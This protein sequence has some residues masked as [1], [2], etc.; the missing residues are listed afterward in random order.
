MLP[1]AYWDCV[2]TSDYLDFDAQ[3][4]ARASPINAPPPASRPMAYDTGPRWVATPFLYRTFTGDTLPAC[5]RFPQ[6]PAS[7]SVHACGLR[8]R[9]VPLVLHAERSR[10]C[11]P[12]F[13]TTSAPPTQPITALNTQP[14]RPSV[15]A[16]PPP[17][18]ATAYDSRPEWIATPFLYDFFIRC[19]CQLDWRFPGSPA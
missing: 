11:L 6:F 15:N 18:R 3:W 19:T 5:W 10:C 17:S 13:Q 1:S 16:P 9:E 7:V 8:R 2:G 4:P 14:I 12:P